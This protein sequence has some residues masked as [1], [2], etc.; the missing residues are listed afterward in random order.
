MKKSGSKVFIFLNISHNSGDWSDQSPLWTP[1]LKKKYKVENRD[2]GVF[3]MTMKDF[4]YYFN[5]VE[6]LYFK[7]YF[8]YN[9]I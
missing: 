2:D 7:E 4:K 9:L 5:D 8:K 1:E 3:Y 6:F